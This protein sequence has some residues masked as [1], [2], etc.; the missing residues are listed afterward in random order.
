MPREDCVNR[1]LY[2]TN[3]HTHYIYYCIYTQN[4]ILAYCTSHN[5]GFP[6]PELVSGC[7]GALDEFLLRD[8]VYVGAKGKGPVQGQYG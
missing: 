8:H 6:A 3:V 4:I 5:Q 2:T 7:F 1:A